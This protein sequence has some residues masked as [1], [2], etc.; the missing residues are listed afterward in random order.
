MNCE[1]PR[2]GSAR[3]WDVGESRCLAVLC[4]LHCSLTACAISASN[5]L[6]LPPSGEVLSDR[7]IG[8]A[9]KA[10]AVGCEDG[11]LLLLAVAARA[12]LARKTLP[13]AVNAFSLICPEVLAIGLEN[14]QVM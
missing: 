12:E 1:I 7:E 10:L 6:E 2:D 8:T 3:L 5:Q 11:T 13:S 14:G 4:E 9:G